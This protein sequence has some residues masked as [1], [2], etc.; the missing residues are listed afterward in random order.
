MGD[1]KGGFRDFLFL[2]TG[3]MQNKNES[4]FLDKIIV[5]Y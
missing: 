2:V 1:E 5:F 4:L 3:Y